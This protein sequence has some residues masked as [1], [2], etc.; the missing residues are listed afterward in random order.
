MVSTKWGYL[1]DWGR[2]RIGTHLDELAGRVRDAIL[3]LEQDQPCDTLLGKA[4]D[5]RRQAQQ[6]EQAALEHHLEACLLPE[7]Q[8]LREIGV[9]VT[10]MSERRT[11]ALIAVERS[12]PIGEHVRA[13]VPLDAKLMARVL[14]SIF[15]PGNPLHDGGVVIREDRILAAA[16]LFPLAA[17]IPDTSRKFGTRHRAALGLSEQCNALVIV[18]SEE[19]GSVSIALGGRLYP[20]PET[21]LLVDQLMRLSGKVPG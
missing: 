11:G 4:T 9:A 20:V 7:I 3:A 16:C 17:A 2:A 12:M 6:V 18:V 21:R 5:I 8:G 19:T 15:Y 14:E 1:S 13:G 10:R